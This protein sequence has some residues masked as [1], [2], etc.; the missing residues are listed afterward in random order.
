MNAQTFFESIAI[1]LAKGN[2]WK[3]A[4]C[5]PHD[6]TGEY[7]GQKI[8]GK[9]VHM[10]LCPKPLEMASSSLE[11]IHKWAKREPNANVCVYARQEAGGLCFLDKDGAH[12]LRAAYEKETG[13]KFPKTLLVRSSRR[14][15]TERGHFYFLQTP[16][17]ITFENNIPESKTD[18][19][20]SFRVK[21]E[22]VCTIGSIH[23]ETKEPYTV[24]ED[25][26]ILPM[27]DDLLDWLQAQTKRKPKTRK[28]AEAR[29][30]LKKGYR[31]TALI[32][33]VGRLWQAGWS[34]ELVISAG[35]EWARQNYEL[36]P[37]EGEFDAQRV[38]K[39]IEHLIDSYPQDNKDELYVVHGG[40]LCAVH[41][42]Q[43]GRGDAKEWIRTLEPLAN[44]D[45]RIVKQIILDDGVTTTAA[46]VIHGTRKNGKPLPETRV[47]ATDFPTMGW[48]AREWTVHSAS[49]RPGMGVKDKLRAGIEFLS[50]DPVLER[51]FTHT[52]W[53]RL[54]TGWAFLHADGAIGGEAQVDLSAPSLQRYRLPNCT[55][56]KT[57]AASAMRISL[58]LL[59]VAPDSITVPL[60][61]AMFRAP[62]ASHLPLNFTI[63]LDAPTGNVKTSLATLFLSHFG[64]FD[65]N[66]SPANW[67][68]TANALEHQAFLLQDL[69][70][71]ID[72]YVP[73]SARDVRELE[74]KASRLIRSQG[75]LTGRGR[76][77]QNLKQRQSFP[78]RGLIVST[79][80][81]RPPGESLAARCI[82]LEPRRN[83]VKLEKLTE[84]QRL[85]EHLPCA[86]TN[87][88]SWL[89][90]QLDNLGPELLKM[91]RDGRVTMARDAAHLRVPETVGSV[92]IGAE[93][94]LRYAVGCKAIDEKKAAELRERIDA[95][96]TNT[97][98]EH[99]TRV[100]DENPARRFLRVLASAL[101][102]GQALMWHKDS[103]LFPPMDVIGWY[104][105]DRLYFLPE[106]AQKTVAEFCQKQGETFNTRERVVREQLNELGVLERSEG[107][108]TR[109]AALGGKVRRV[110]QLIRNNAEAL[111]DGA[112]FPNDEPKM[113]GKDDGRGKK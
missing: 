66:H 21:N 45:A 68:S 12:D 61:A 70:L 48:V 32:S 110:L 31:Y 76:M 113:H 102:S 25:N 51:I 14:N 23:P 20:F 91:Q 101:D 83:T 108:L 100:R 74:A 98:I 40:E 38:Q 75:N 1:P 111:V 28:E 71:L 18:G 78:P 64:E 35:I 43:K 2:G 26:P 86:M 73:T 112:S 37:T 63:W 72:E 29:G 69:P 96:L 79:G 85:A 103:D 22:Y 8:D 107:S 5:F 11:Q 52:G 58:A 77:D 67:S 27:P 30:K 3:I 54:E 50:A 81:G 109:T 7:N 104:D 53:V 4:P 10:K 46:H 6:A 41:W 42:E 105:K 33:E 47:L 57:N 19:W 92:G 82:V 87:Y 15:G 95:A 106:V 13:K 56:G 49:L 34:R 24:V 84:A 90:P 60:W 9:T 44:F 99:A 80:E 88:L 65:V 59:D 94:A 36:L 16:R 93:L 55:D 62:L 17:T 97:V 39:R 89:A